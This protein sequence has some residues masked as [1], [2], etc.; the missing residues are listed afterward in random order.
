MKHLLQCIPLIWKQLAWQIWPNDPVSEN[1][2]LIEDF[3]I[4]V[5]VFFI[6]QAISSARF[7]AGPNSTELLKQVSNEFHLPQFACYSSWVSEKSEPVEKLIQLLNERLPQGPDADLCVLNHGDFRLDNIIIHPKN[8][9]VIAVLVTFF[10]S[11]FGDCN[12]V[13]Y[14]LFF[15]A[16]LGTG[17]SWPPYFR[18]GLQLLA[19]PYP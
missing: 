8:N 4:D 6:P 15:F 11:L 10:N 9:T 7:P 19:V 18:F 14:L 13:V 12:S 17:H 3:L 16:G 5:V 2:V 1:L